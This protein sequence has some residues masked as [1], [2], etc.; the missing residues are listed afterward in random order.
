M[1][2]DRGPSQFQIMYHQA[3][4]DRIPNCPPVLV[5]WCL[6]WDYWSNDLILLENEFGVMNSLGKGGAN[7]DITKYLSHVG[8]VDWAAWL[9]PI[10]LPYWPLKSYIRW[11]GHDGRDYVDA[12]NVCYSLILK[13]LLNC[14]PKPNLIRAFDMNNEHRA[15]IV[16]AI[17][18]AHQ[19]TAGL[20]R[21]HT[22]VLFP[23]LREE[24]MRRWPDQIWERWNNVLSELCATMVA[25]LRI[26]AIVNVS[27]EELLL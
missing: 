4:V 2:D 24:T 22:Y 15:D 18:G 6:Q 13:C 10:S 27:V 5:L 3:K 16:E 17:L 21:W 25:V 20:V 9:E 8:G 7:H 12:G 11:T 14:W 1:A 19:L 26:S 23:G